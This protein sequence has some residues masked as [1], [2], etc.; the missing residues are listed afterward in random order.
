MLLSTVCVACR[1]CDDEF[2]SVCAQ[3]HWV[4]EAL[5]DPSSGPLWACVLR[6]G[7]EIELLATKAGAKAG[8]PSD[9]VI[10]ACCKAASRSADDARSMQLALERGG[11]VRGTFQSI[12]KCDQ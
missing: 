10:L 11:L 4:F 8:T 12:S 9:E 7:Q 1:H 3:G 6:P 5:S 2:E